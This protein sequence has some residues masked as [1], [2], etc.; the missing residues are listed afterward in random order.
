MTDSQTLLSEYVSAGSEPAFRELVGRYLDLVYSSALR[1][2]GGDAQLAEDVSQTVFLNLARKARGLPRNVMLGGWGVSLS[3]V[4]L[5]TALATHT[6]TA[7]PGG[8]AASIAGS[9]LV[10]AGAGVGAWTTILQLA[11]MT[12]TQSC[13]LGAIVLLGVAASVV[14]QHRAQAAIHA[15]DEALGRQSAELARRQSENERLPALARGGAGENTLEALANTRREV[16]SLRQQAASRD[17]G[18]GERPST[19]LPLLRKEEEAKEFRIAQM[20]YLSRW[21]AAFHAFAKAKGNQFPTSFEEARSFLPEEAKSE[22]NLTPGHFEI[23]YRGPATDVAT[24]DR[25]VVLRERQPLRAYDGGWTRAY[26][27]ADGH[28]EI[29]MTLDGDYTAWEKRHIVGPPVEQ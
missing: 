29:S 11:T 6:I 1:L 19:F 2:V 12:K 15:Q 13:L 8:L 16:E 3:A 4:A 7:A 10:G 17:A 25:V 24:P 26:G 27:F 20:S 23:V 5:G 18:S 9:A 28:A 21:L 14:I 22:T